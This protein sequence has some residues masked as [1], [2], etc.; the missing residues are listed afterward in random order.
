MATANVSHVVEHIVPLVHFSQ[1]VAM[2]DGLSVRFG[3]TPAQ[4]D[5]IAFAWLTG[6]N[7]RDRFR[8][9]FRDDGSLIPSLAGRT[10]WYEFLQQSTPKTMTPPT[11][12]PKITTSRDDRNERSLCVFEA[13]EEESDEDP[14][15]NLFRSLV[16][17]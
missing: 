11:T 3:L 8:H 14:D 1:V 7:G 2:K 10:N 4:W 6:P 15:E 9:F 12:P 13:I 16:C 5:A 17:Y